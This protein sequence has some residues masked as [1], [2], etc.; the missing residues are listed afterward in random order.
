MQTATIEREVTFTAADRCDACGAQAVIRAH[1]NSGDLLFC[2]HHGRR[3]HE[4]LRSQG[5]RIEDPTG[6]LDSQM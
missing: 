2:A 5:A 1:L 4:K 3:F 6:S